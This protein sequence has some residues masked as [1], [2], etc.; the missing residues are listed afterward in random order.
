MAVFTTT[1]TSHIDI[2][3]LP[4]FGIGLGRYSRPVDARCV[5]SIMLEVISGPL[6]DLTSPIVVN[7][8]GNRLVECI[9]RFNT[10]IAFFAY[11]TVS[12]LA[13]LVCMTPKMW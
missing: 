6:I 13:S 5:T 4:E 7:V 8:V 2:E 9:V 10:H 11:K 12:R 1:A 3:S